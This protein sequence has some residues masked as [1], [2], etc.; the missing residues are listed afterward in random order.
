MTLNKI[1]RPVKTQHSRRH[2]YRGRNCVSWYKRLSVLRPR[3][4]FSSSIQA[5]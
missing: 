1:L 3:V 2:I 5:L 4:Q